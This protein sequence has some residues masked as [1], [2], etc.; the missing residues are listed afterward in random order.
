MTLRMVSTCPDL[1]Q[2]FL[3]LEWGFHEV[4]GELPVGTPSLTGIESGLS[5]SFK[6]LEEPGLVCGPPAPLKGLVQQLLES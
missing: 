6:L 3:G 1:H 2:E 4:I 5:A